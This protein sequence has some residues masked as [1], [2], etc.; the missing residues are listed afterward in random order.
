MQKEGKVCTFLSIDD[1]FSGRV[2]DSQNAVCPDEVRQEL[3]PLGKAIS[4]GTRPQNFDWR[5][6][7]ID[8]IALKERL[9]I[10]TSSPQKG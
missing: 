7:G 6:I 10:S 2:R 3:E 5:V 8:T 4:I 1:V 9:R